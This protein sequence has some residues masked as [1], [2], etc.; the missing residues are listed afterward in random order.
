MRKRRGAIRVALLLLTGAV[1]ASLWFG[2]TPQAVVDHTK[3]D[4]DRMIDSAQ[5]CNDSYHD[6]E[7]FRR[8]YGPQVEIGEFPVSGLRICLDAD[9]KEGPQWVIL[10]GTANFTN[11]VEDLEFNGEDEH[12]L[13]IPV[14]AGFDRSLQ[15][16]L[17]WVI[18]RLDPERPVWVTG[19]SLGGAVAELLIATLEN[20][21][22]KDVSGITFGQR[23]VTDTRRGIINEC[24]YHILF[25]FLR[26]GGG[27]SPFAA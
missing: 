17:P 16:C 14:H 2:K 19:H 5:R 18:Q 26:H 12:E 24:S 22:F 25:A 7:T 9:P 20:R 11:V 1:A 13:G 27:R 21:G 10:R 23:K 3:I 8:E 15:E 4:L 6:H